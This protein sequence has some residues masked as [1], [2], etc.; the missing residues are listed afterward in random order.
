MFEKGN[1]ASHP[2]LD[3]ALDKEQIAWEG[4]LKNK[5]EAHL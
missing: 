3:T 4:K 1:A 2:N 5:A